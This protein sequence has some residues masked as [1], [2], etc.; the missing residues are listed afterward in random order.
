MADRHDQIAQQ[1]L[2]SRAPEPAA[3]RW[4]IMTSEQKFEITAK[5]RAEREELMKA[6]GVDMSV[7][8]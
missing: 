4:V 8:D 3:H 6:Y 2:E 5:S 1:L 7:D